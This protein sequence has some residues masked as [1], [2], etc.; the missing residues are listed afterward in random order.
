MKSGI[1]NFSL[2]LYQIK[3]DSHYTHIPK[4]ELFSGMDPY[5]LRILKPEDAPVPIIRIFF[6]LTAR[7][8]CPN[9]TR[10]DP[11]MDK[12]YKAVTYDIWCAG[13]SSEVLSPIDVLYTHIWGT[14]LQALYGWQELYKVDTDEEQNL[15][16]LMNPGTVSNDGHWSRWVF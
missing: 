9:V 15:Q 8:P 16:M 10:H 4:L 2:M 1:D 3:N 11:V 7:T 13:L 5:K 14:L 12:N 6:A